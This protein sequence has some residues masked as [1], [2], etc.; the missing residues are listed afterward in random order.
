MRCDE[1]R[2]LMHE[3]LDG[4]EAAR[5][6]LGAHLADCADC[7]AEFAAL[8]RAQE[9]VVATVA[10][11]PPPERLQRAAVAALAVAH[12]PRRERSPW[13]VPAMSMW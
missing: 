10:G 3:A 13:M 11:E 4:A 12:E 2:E 8:R 5:E 7:A 9:A 6:R 1:A